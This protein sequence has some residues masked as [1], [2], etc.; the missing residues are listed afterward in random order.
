LELLTRKATLLVRLKCLYKKFFVRLPKG[1]AGLNIFEEF[2]F[3]LT[4]V[5]DY[6]CK[7]EK[8]WLEMLAKH[9]GMAIGKKKKTRW[10]ASNN[11][12][13]ILFV[14]GIVDNSENQNGEI[15]LSEFRQRD[16]QEKISRRYSVEKSIYYSQFLLSIF[17]NVW[18]LINI[19]VKIY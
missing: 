2:F 5:R 18:N 17:C 4:I 8:I 7:E 13:Q 14:H 19:I 11:S 12:R 16:L 6:E 10:V 15:K 9:N 3:V 1:F